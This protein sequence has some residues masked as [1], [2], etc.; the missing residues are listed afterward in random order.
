M[1]IDLSFGL[2]ISEGATAATFHTKEK[3]K[4]SLFT[5]ISRTD[6]HGS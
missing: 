4:M 6:I 1:A 5:L 3:R 2:W